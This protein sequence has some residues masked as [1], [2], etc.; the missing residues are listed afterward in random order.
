MRKRRD[1]R[2]AGLGL[3][4]DAHVLDRLRDP[5]TGVARREGHFRDD[6]IC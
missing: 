1:R 4:P 3:E 6:T 2:N 5:V